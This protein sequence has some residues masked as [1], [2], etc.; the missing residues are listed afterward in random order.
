M[1]RENMRQKISPTIKVFSKN[2]FK[3]PQINDIKMHLDL[4][5]IKREIMSRA[6]HATGTPTLASDSLMSLWASLSLSFSIVNC[7][8]TT[9]THKHTPQI[10]IMGTHTLQEAQR[11]TKRHKWGWVRLTGNRKT[12]T[13]EQVQYSHQ[14]QSSQKNNKDVLHTVNDNGST[15]LYSHFVWTSYLMCKRQSRVYCTFTLKTTSNLS[16]K[17]RRRGAMTAWKEQG[18]ASLTVGVPSKT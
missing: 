3:A 14:T 1:Q 4:S 15:V 17:E 18:A 10:H 9:H 11:A 16:S 8:D 7:A 13:I 2:R 12:S 6:T 5:V